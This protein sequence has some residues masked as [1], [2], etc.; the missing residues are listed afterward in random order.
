MADQPEDTTTDIQPVEPATEAPSETKP[1]GNADE[2]QVKEP[3]TEESKAEETEPKEAVESE[4]KEEE[5]DKAEEPEKPSEDDEAARKRHNDEMAKQRIAQSNQKTRQEVLK[6]V[7][8]SYG[9]AEVEEP[10]LDGLSEAEAK[11]AQLQYQLEQDR[12]QREFEKQR[13]FIADLNTGLKNDAE[14]VMRDHPVYDEKSPSY[15]PT[16]TKEVEEA[17]KQAARLEIDENG[18]VVNAEVPLGEFYD[19]MAK[20]REGGIQRGEIQ[21]EKD[22]QTMESRTESTGSTNTKSTEKSPE[23]MTIQEMEA[24]YGI[25]RR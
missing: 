22:K 13:D 23:D 19:R 2:V 6:K 10:K 8:A 24:K 11:I 18:I 7:D 25:V 9:P 12:A 17:Y 14:L 1:E 3:A 4:A 20:I 21:R 5:G 16:F 15:D